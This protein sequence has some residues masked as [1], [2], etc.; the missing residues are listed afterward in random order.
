VK[1]TDTFSYTL[2]DVVGSSLYAIARVTT[3]ITVTDT[4]L[5]TGAIT[6]FTMTAYDTRVI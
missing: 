4:I 5:T 6:T 2:Y 1:T 3:G